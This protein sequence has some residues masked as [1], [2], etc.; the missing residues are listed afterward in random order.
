CEILLGIGILPLKTRK[1][2]SLLIM[3]MLLVFTVLH[4]QMIIDTYQAGGWL[5]WIAVFRL[6]LQYVLIRWS[7]LVYKKYNKPF[8]FK[9]P[10]YQ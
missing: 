10:V 4:V 5:F 2:S 7:W 6:P 8:N 3:A 1:A 9:K